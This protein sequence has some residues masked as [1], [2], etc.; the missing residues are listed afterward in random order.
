MRTASE[1]EGDLAHAV[2]RREETERMFS[3]AAIT[4]RRFKELH[5]PQEAAVREL[6]GRLGDARRK[7]AEVSGISAGESPAGWSSRWPAW[8]AE[9]R[10][11]I[12]ATFVDRF[13]AGT[14]EIE[15]AYLLPE[16]PAPEEPAE[17]RQINIPTNQPQ[18]GGPVYVRLPKPGEKCPI[19]G[20]SRAKLNELILPNERNGF[21]PPVVSR[22]LRQKG[23]QRGIRPVLLES[24]MAYLSGS[25]L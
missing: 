11:R 15:I 9:R 25:T 19:T 3:G 18:P 21:R 16:P 23:A 14:D 4:K 17:P 13:V 10:R 8:P 22:S 7:L 1:I 24:L 20:L 12:I 2:K 5:V 6:E